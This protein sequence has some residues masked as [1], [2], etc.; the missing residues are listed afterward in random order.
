MPNNNNYNHPKKRYSNRHPRE[1]SSE[2]NSTKAPASEFCSYTSSIAYSNYYFGLNLFDLY[3]PEQLESI[4]KD[5]MSNNEILRKL[6]LQLYS[7]NGVFAN[8]VDYLTALHTL[9]RVIVTRG[10]R[11]KRKKHNKELLESTLKTVRD[12]EFIR[13]ALLKGMVEGAAYYYFETTKRPYSNQKMLTDYDVNS[14]AEINELGINASIISLPADYTRVIGKKNSSYVVAFN[15]DYFTSGSTEDIEKR[16]IKF[17]KEI[18]DA[19]NKKYS[20]G[21]SNGNWIVLDN[22]HTIVHKIKSKSDE[23]YGRPL[24][25][26]AIRDILYENE[27]IQT[28]RNVLDEINNR[29]F[30]QTFPEGK[31]KGVSALTKQQQE[32]QHEAV[33]GAI[34]KKKN[35]GGVSFFSVAAGTKINKIE[36]T[37]TDIFDE[38]NEANL[39]DKIALGLGVAASLLNGV[40]SGNYAAQQTNL[41]LISAQLF[42]WVDAISNELNKC[43]SATIIKDSRNSVECKYLPITYVNRNAMVGYMKDLYLQSGGSMS[44]YIAA[45]GISPEVYYA[46]LDEEIDNGIFEKYKPHM[47]SYTLSSNDVSSSSGGRPETEE[48]TENTIKSRENDGN[49]LPSPSDDE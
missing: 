16:L 4:I 14:I 42:Q 34:L 21:K 5:P 30:Y 31:D 33:K 45:C 7:T 48:P 28:K 13:D 2:L 1:Q 8:T 36:C 9:D 27:F 17:P 40:G 43:I 10:K 22:N 29:I 41:E 35:R 3:S 39:S 26:P 23:P 15:L 47:T 46:L 49:G 37:T 24:V 18:R 19:Y 6:S 32:N 12:R 44:A 20:P 25:L 11:E 38:K